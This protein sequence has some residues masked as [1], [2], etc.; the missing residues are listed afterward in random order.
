MAEETP[1][2]EQMQYLFHACA[3]QFRRYESLDRAKLEGQPLSIVE[4]Q[5][6]K[7]SADMNGRFADACE[8]FAVA[9]PQ[10]EVDGT[11]K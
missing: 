3:V 2:V 7:K 8:V 9:P 5:Q 6:T 11:A 4:A 10:L 1:D